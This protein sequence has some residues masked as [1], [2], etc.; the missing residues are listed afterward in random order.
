MEAVTD[1]QG[2]WRGIHTIPDDSGGL[3]GS[4]CDGCGDL[5]IVV[6][7]RGFDF[8]A[9]TTVEEAVRSAVA[10]ANGF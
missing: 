9:G 4:R 3:W 5:M 8:P 1:C 6:H 7:G 10:Q 2:Q